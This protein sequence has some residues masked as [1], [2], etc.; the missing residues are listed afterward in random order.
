MR[1]CPRD[2]TAHS[3]PCLHFPGYS[4]ILNYKWLFRV[5]VRLSVR[6]QFRQKKVNGFFSM[7]ERPAEDVQKTKKMRVEQTVRM[8]LPEM[9][10]SA[11]NV[12][13]RQ[14]KFVV[15]FCRQKQSC[16]ITPPCHDKVGPVF[17]F[18]CSFGPFFQSAPKCPKV[19]KSQV[20]SSEAA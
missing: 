19:A 11:E 2:N 8:R 18:S 9:S 13:F 6:S 15:E 10:S 12:V 4:L 17:S 3:T 5:S 16:C 20:G 7:I 14:E 1:N